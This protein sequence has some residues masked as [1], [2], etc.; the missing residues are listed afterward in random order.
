MKRFVLASASP[1]RREL[2]LGAGYDF[3]VLASNADES[4]E[5]GT[6]AK[7][8]VE[9]LCERKAKDVLSKR[10]DCVVLG[11]DTVVSVDGKILGK[12]KDELQA[13]QMLKMLSGKKHCVYSGVCIADKDR[14]VNFCEK[15]EVEFYE[16]SESTIN[17]YIST[18]EP[19]DKAGSY[20]IQGFGSVLVKGIYGDYYSVVGLPLAKTVRVLSGF[21]IKGKIE[22]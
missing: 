20:G 18:K 10:Q 5:S 14:T 12:P 16:L 15:T 19:M 8:A 6:D 9:I 1:R 4:I 11:C 17:S 2:L 3:E 13:K 22:L 21:G 7:R